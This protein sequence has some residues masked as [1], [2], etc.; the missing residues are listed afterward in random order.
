MCR[1]ANTLR[2]ARLACETWATCRCGPCTIGEAVRPPA[3]AVLPRPLEHFRAP[4]TQQD[5]LSWALT[6]YALAGLGRLDEVLQRRIKA[7]LEPCVAGGNSS[8]TFQ[9]VALWP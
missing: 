2:R 5:A 6:T 9:S 4:R 3:E 8:V 7:A 1:P